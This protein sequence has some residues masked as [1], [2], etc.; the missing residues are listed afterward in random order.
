MPEVK[1]TT[2]PTGDLQTALRQANSLLRTNP[3][4]AEEQAGIILGFVPDNIEAICIL[5]TAKRLLGRYDEA[6][7]IITKAH[8]AAPG[9]AAVHHEM[10]LLYQVMGDHGGAIAAFRRAVDISPDRAS[11]WKELAQLLDGDEAEEAL[12]HSLINSKVKP[13]VV[14]ASLYLMDGKLAKAE[15]LLR[16]HLI[17]NPTDVNAI[18]LLAD[19]AIKLNVYD[20]AEKLL[21]RC[22][23]L[24]PDFHQAR[25]NLAN[26]YHKRQKYEQALIEIARLQR[27]QPGNVAYKMLKATVLSRLGNFNDAIAL[28]EGILSTTPEQ[29]RVLL[30]YGHALKTVG[31]Q[32]D[33]VEAYTKAY[34]VNP[35]LGEAFWSLAN[36]KVYQF[37]GDVIGQM[38]QTLKKDKLDPTDDYHLSFALGK[39]LEDQGEYSDA[40]HY[41]DRGNKLKQVEL[42]YD[43]D[44]TERTTQRMMR[45][46]NRALFDQN[47]GCGFPDNSPIFIV[48]LPRSGSTLLEQILASHPDVDGTMELPD[49][50]SIARRLSGKRLRSDPSA[51]P[52]ILQSMD[53]EA[54]YKLGEEYIERTHVQRGKAMFFIDKMP[55]NFLHLGLIHFILPNAKIIDARRSPMATCFSGFKQLFA[56]GQEFTYSLEN[57]GR[58]YRNYVA[59]MDH[60]HQMLPDRILHVQYEDVVADLIN[61]VHRILDYCELP[62][63]EGCLSFHQTQ[64]AVRTASSEQVRQPIYKDSLE[65][66]KAFEAHLQPLKM[67]LGSDLSE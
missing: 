47:K 20:D 37:N 12:K 54:F 2:Q 46:C 39:A 22:L 49:I 57:I 26:V 24:A 41:Y 62:F 40:F 50:I 30:S 31:R 32:A 28:Y 11:S 33:A 18:R 65:R 35:T 61:Q 64:R 55:N 21:E 67:A 9:T 45:V 4:L 52:D 17:A 63:H 38:K 25:S 53:S 15:L 66:W 19:V 16:E 3:L 14:Q 44:D 13:N 8:D 51:Y 29:S 42:K 1:K 10:G 60:W 27:V 5:S 59:L 43:A 23:D 36:L 48:G 7:V 56:Q 58:Y 34:T 6:L